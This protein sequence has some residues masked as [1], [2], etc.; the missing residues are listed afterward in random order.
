MHTPCFAAQVERALAPLAESDAPGHHFAAAILYSIP[1]AQHFALPENGRLFDD[2]LRGLDADLRTLRLPYPIITVSFANERGQKTLVVAREQ[3]KP[4]APIGLVIE[5]MV[6]VDLNDGDGWGVVPCAASPHANLE[7]DVV[8]WFFSGADGKKPADDRVWGSVG[9]AGRSVLEL[10]EALSCNNVAAE[11]VERIDPAVNARRRRQ[12]KLPLYEVHR[13]VV[14]VGDVAHAIGAPMGD[15][16]GPREHLRRGHIRRL[17][18]GRKTW[19]QACVVGSR[20][21]GVIRKSAYVVEV[22]RAPA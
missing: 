21:L 1:R 5:V 7:G 17:P 3:E 14:K 22:E 18:D 6:A 15:R 13:L 4:D 10:V 16:G 2:Q 12:G 8:E 19:V 9:Q 11:V 20:A